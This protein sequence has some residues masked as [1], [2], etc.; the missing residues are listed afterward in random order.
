MS[1]VPVCIDIS[2]WQDFPD[3]DEVRAAGVL[4]V[5]H[6]ATEGT[7]YVDPNRAT[8]CENALKAGLA[9]STYFWIK[10]GDGRAQAEFYLQTTDPEPGERV[11]IDY[12]EDGCSLTTLRDAVQALLDYGDDLQITVYS[13]HLLKEQLGDECDEFLRDNTDLWLA[14]YTSDEDDISWPSGTYDQWTLWQYSET[15]TIPGIDDNYVD[16]NR[17]NGDDD[18][19]LE[20]IMPAGQVP[21]PIPQ[22]TPSKDVVAVAITV[23]EGVKVTIRVNGAAHKVNEL[24]PV[25]RSPDIDR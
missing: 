1:D 22:P 12:E 14:Q 18:D 10:P 6:K 17:Y 5:I 13:G 11:V 25:K 19:F 3:F 7:S 2:H 8:N 24:R 21:P 4:G 9:V 23:P 20:W 16:L 15:G